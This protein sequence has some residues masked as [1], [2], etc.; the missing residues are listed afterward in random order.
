MGIKKA[1]VLDADHDHTSETNNN[2]I[3]PKKQQLSNEEM[4]AIFY[5]IMFPKG[6]KV[7]LVAVAS[8]I[9]EIYWEQLVPVEDQQ[10][11]NEEMQAIFN[12][13]MFPKGNEAGLVAVAS[14]INGIY[15][16]RLMAVEDWR[17]GIPPVNG[18]ISFNTFR[19]DL[20]HT[21]RGIRAVRHLNALFADIDCYK[22]GIPIND[23]L[24]AIAF[25][26]K[27]ERILEPTMINFTGRGLCVIWKIED[28]PGHSQRA[29]NLYNHI[30]TY[31]YELFKELGADRQAKDISHVFRIPGTIN[32]KTGETVRFLQVNEENVY[33]LREF[34]QFVDPFEEYKD[35]KPGRKK[36]SVKRGEVKRLPVRN[37]FTMDASRC[38]DLEYL[39]KMRDYDM[40]GYRN[41][42]L[43]IYGYF[44]CKAHGL[45]ADV[46]GAVQELNER[47][48]E[49]YKTREVESIV[50]SVQAA[51][52]AHLQNPAKG[53]NYKHK[54]IIDAL[55]I[56][57][58][59]QAEMRVLI[60]P[61][62][63]KARKNE[64][65]RAARR[66]ESGMTKRQADKTYLVERV[67]ELKERGMKQKDIAEML[68]ITKGRV[69]QILKA[70]KTV[71]H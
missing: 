26:V 53:Y 62:E 71:A 20:I 64:R 19:G 28:V 46:L 2:S 67:K 6:N 49:P 51:Y 56:S 66:D 61:G 15:R 7:R 45:E 21:T 4:Q 58:E 41:F 47:F 63:K 13:I 57:E 31:I 50:R 42:V 59:E 70:L 36:K 24:S 10:L 18:Y 38:A 27:H 23:V 30:Q 22:E 69:S 17:K 44:Y 68:G 52:K 3:L 60:T 54:S 12:K 9:D 34:Q 14:K 8:K 11:S 55:D 65:E 33:T 29:R 16:E 32:S 35:Y 40:K 25:Q 48:I 1:L 5:E 43:H 37:N 39:C